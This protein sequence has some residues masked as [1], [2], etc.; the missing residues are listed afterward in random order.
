MGAS[1]S[2]AGSLRAALPHPVADQLWSVQPH[3]VLSARLACHP[4]GSLALG[5][6]GAEALERLDAV[7][8]GPGLGAASTDELAAEQSSWER[9][10][11][12]SG[13][14]LLDADGLNRLAR[15]GARAWLQARRGP[16][17]ITPHPGEFGAA[18][19]RSGDDAPLEAAQAAA[20][21]CSGDHP[22]SAVLKGARSVIAAAD[23]RRWQLRQ[24]SGAAARA[25]LGDVLAGYAGGLGARQQAAHG[26]LRR[27][28]A[29][30]L[31]PRPCQCRPGRSA[32]TR[33]RRRRCH[34]RGATAATAGSKQQHIPA[35]RF[36]KPFSCVSLNKQVCGFA[37]ES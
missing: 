6:L 29:G 18:V 9:L 25:G 13:L 28:P 14:L 31:R 37:A 23:G 5:G 2:G 19:P 35:R 15:L 3:V 32:T 10:Q 7:V 22:C 16:T 24:A 30:R 11:H 20:M 27:R 21:G 33:P 26:R 17:W 36:T 4:S 1:A 12:F 34:G 8:I